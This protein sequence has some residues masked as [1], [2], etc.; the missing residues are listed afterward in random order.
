VQVGADGLEF[1]N[2]GSWG[3]SGWEGAGY[4]EKRGY[5]QWGTHDTAQE[6]PRSV[7]RELVRRLRWGYANDGLIK[8]CVDGATNL[9]G[10]LRCEPTSGDDAWDELAVEHFR[11]RAGFPEAF[12]RAGKLSFEDWQLQ[13]TRCHMLDGDSLTVRTETPESK[14]GRIIFYEGHQVD[15]GQDRDA[16]E[17]LRDGVF[18]DRFGRARGYRLVDPSDDTRWS[19]VKA[20]DALLYAEYQRAG[21]V[22]GVPRLAH[23]INHLIDIIETTG[24]V[25]HGIKT[26]HQVAMMMLRE[27]PVSGPRG[28]QAGLNRSPGGSLAGTPGTSNLLSEEVWSSGNVQHL[29]QGEKLQI[30]HDERPHPNHMEF[31]DLLVRGIAWGLG[32]PPEVLWKVSGLGSAEVRYVMAETARWIELEQRRLARACQW[33][34]GYF[35]AKEIAAGRLP[36]PEGGQGETRQGT[37]AQA[38]RGGGGCPRRL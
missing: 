25:K 18:V 38:H 8:R 30:L 16:P 34:Y 14:M 15:T 5:V 17:S 23:A 26:S 6:L 19:Q 13:L 29:D 37:G 28:L 22:R 3:G 9:V 7:R 27:Q 32:L 11:Q 24:A 12:D 4:S 21:H 36:M 2:L 10:T 31:T 20:A 1:R 35:I 33:F